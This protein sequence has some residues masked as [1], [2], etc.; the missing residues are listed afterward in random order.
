MIIVDY[1]KLDQ[2][3]DSLMFIPFEKIDKRKLRVR[4]DTGWTV[5]HQMKLSGYKFPETTYINYIKDEYGT[6]VADI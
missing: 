6:S 5:A 3:A 1:K 4:L 2:I